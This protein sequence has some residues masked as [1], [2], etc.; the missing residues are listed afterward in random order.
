MAGSKDKD[1]HP[2][3][4]GTTSAPPR[5]ARPNALNYDN[6]EVRKKFLQVVKAGVYKLGRRH[7]LD[8]IELDFTRHSVL[9]KS[10][11]DGGK[12]TD[13]QLK[14]I[15][16]L[17][18][19]IR[20]NLDETGAL[21]GRPILLMVRIPDSVAFC[22]AIGIDIE[23][24]LKEGLV[25]MAVN[26]DY[27]MLSSWREFADFCHSY[28]VPYYAC[29]ERRRIEQNVSNA[30]KSP[31]MSVRIRP[32]LWRGEALN[33]WNSGVDGIYIFN[34]PAARAEVFSLNLHDPVLLRRGHFPNI[35]LQTEKQPHSPWV[36]P[37][38][39]ARGWRS[40]P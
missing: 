35:I 12:A 21:R 16:D 31:S 5:F 36:H 2:F 3:L 8:G 13:K 38:R 18:R 15:T 30:S 19:S 17:V 10:V 22:R 23:G 26:S 27:Y 20:Q 32:E 11:A 7:R 25:D 14:L 4:I 40:K 34:R 29:L 6:T 33:A 28:G 1:G 39:W 9:F 37:D 24:W